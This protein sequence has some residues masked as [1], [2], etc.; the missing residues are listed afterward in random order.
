MK[1]VYKRYK[2]REVSTRKNTYAAGAGVA[3]AT[4]DRLILRTCSCTLD[5]ASTIEMGPAGATVDL[6]RTIAVFGV[7]GTRMLLVAGRA[8]VDCGE[9]AW[10]KGRDKSQPE[11]SF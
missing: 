3:F 5:F 8:M 1:D 4:V 10:E 11:E 7:E 2:F 6:H 9:E